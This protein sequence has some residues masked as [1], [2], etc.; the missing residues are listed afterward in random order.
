MRL[1]IS[2]WALPSFGAVIAALAMNLPAAVTYQNPVI[3]GDHPDPSI[4][5]VGKDY[6][7]SCTSSAWGPLFPLLHSRDLVNWEQTGAVLPHRPDWATGD[8][9]AP[10]ISEFN[11]KF[12]VYF[13]ARQRDGHLAV[14]VATADKPG[15]PYKDHGPIIAQDDGSIDPAPVIDTNGVRYLIWKE[16]GNSQRRPTPIWLQRLNDDGTKLVDEPHE[17]IRNDMKWE[18][19]LVEGP[20]ILQRGD[21]FYLF[22]S[23]NG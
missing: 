14:A 8:F 13:V 7:A 11:G 3:P 18:G 15:G 17:L 21:W 2:T 1:K 9:W 19:G 6:W 5:R 16:D 22:Y 12:F 20:F 10:E 23:G 4:I